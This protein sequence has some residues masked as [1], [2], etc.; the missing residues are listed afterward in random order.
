MTYAICIP[1]RNRLR[2]DKKNI[3]NIVKTVP[4]MFQER[5]VE[6]VCSVNWVHE[7][8]GS[9]ER[10]LKG[11]EQDGF[12]THW[13]WN[14]THLGVGEVVFDTLLNGFAT[15]V[16]NL[17]CAFFL[18]VDFDLDASL[19]NSVIS[20]LGRLVEPLKSSP[21]PD[22]VIGDYRPLL[23]NGR[24]NRIKRDLE[25]HVKHLIEYFFPDEWDKLKTVQRPRSEFFG[26]RREFFFNLSTERLIWSVFDP[27]VIALIEAERN[28]R[29]TWERVDL[30]NFYEDPAPR[31][32]QNERRIVRQIHR[33]TY[34]IGNHWTIANPSLDA[35]ELADKLSGVIEIET[36]SLNSVQGWLEVEVD[37]E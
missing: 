30:G 8:T 34:V 1:G 35:T 21:P 15:P 26:I 3:E 2:D 18:A 29:R 5:G 24:P 14:T 25:G 27:T 7:P 32:P 28:P 12:I 19:P 31:D 36:K 22:L 13:K 10:F 20:N 6:C 33:T 4:P 11:L 37:G 23:K 17:E 16:Q 9:D